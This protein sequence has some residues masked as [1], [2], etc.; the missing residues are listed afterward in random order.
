MSFRTAIPE[1]QLA[2]PI[3]AGARVSFYTVDVN[4]VITTTLAT[5]YAGPSGLATASNPQTLDGEGKFLA[6]VYFAVDVIAQV[7]GPNVPS[8]VTGV[9]APGEPLPEGFF[10]G[11]LFSV[12]RNGVAQ[13]GL[14]PST[15]NLIRFTTK[16]VDV[17]GAFDNVTNFRYQPTEAGWYFISA[18]GRAS[19]AAADQPQIALFKSGSL[20]RSGTWAG[21]TSTAAY[22]TVD[23]LVFLNG[24]TH[25]IDARMY[26]PA[27]IVALTGDLDALELFGWRVLG[28]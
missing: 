8:H 3:Y 12:H 7:A 6:P 17:D 25:Y 4:G 26:L 27:A 15:Y 11:G 14:T 28:T 2:N 13:A 21:A 22:T 5:L 10:L 9:I 24:T 20:L 1:F 16:L 19:G 18:K 23:T